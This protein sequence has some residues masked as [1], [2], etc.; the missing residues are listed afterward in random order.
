MFERYTDRARRA[1]V[2]AQEESRMLSHNYIGTEH[3]LLGLI[4]EGEGVA[5]KAL[6]SLGVSLDAVRG[7]VEEIIGRGQETPKGHIPFTP[8]GK[9]VLELSLTESLQLGCNYIGT[10]HI[11]LGL[12]RQGE[13]VGAKVLCKL[14]AE[15][16][17][18]RKAVIDL[19]ASYGTNAIPEATPKPAQPQARPT[20]IV[21]AYHAVD[22]IAAA[23]SSLQTANREL[24]YANTQL[25]RKLEDL[26][27]EVATARNTGF[28][29]GYRTARD[30]MERAS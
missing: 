19:L 14:G 2:L 28:D 15:L 21:S 27:A 8:R 30:E 6:E 22:K 5:A 17:P 18:V 23:L 13:G 12:V 25:E 20:S 29:D 10:E 24:Q 1:V 4:H 26:A 7:Q 11:L 3:I 16:T 9:R